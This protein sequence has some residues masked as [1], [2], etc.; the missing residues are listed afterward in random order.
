MLS[1]GTSKGHAWLQLWA[2]HMRQGSVRDVG[3]IAI[4]FVQPQHSCRVLNHSPQWAR[5]HTDSILFLTL[6]NA[7]TCR[8]SK[9]I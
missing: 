8:E 1:I 7:G 6:L 5:Q 2:R 9:T 3:N 4:R